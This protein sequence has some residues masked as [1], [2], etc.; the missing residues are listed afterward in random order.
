LSD[1]PKFA[2]VK[3]TG[4]TSDWTVYHESVC[5][6]TS[7][8]LVLNSTASVGNIQVWGAA[9][10]TSSVIGLTS[11]GAVATNQECIA[12]CWA[13]SSTQSFGS[14][15]GNGSTTGPVIDCGF[16][17]A[18]V[19]IKRTNGA[20]PWNMYDSTRSPSNPANALLLANTSDSETNNSNNNIDFLSTGFQLGTATPE[21][22]GSGDTY[23][24]AAFG[25]SFEGTT[26]ELTDDSG[27]TQFSP[28][29]DIVQNGSGTPVSSA[30]T[31]VGTVSGPIYS[32]TV[33]FTNLNDGTPEDM[34]DGSTSTA[35]VVAATSGSPNSSINWTTLSSMQDGNGNVT[36]AVRIYA[37][38]D[39]TY[40]YPDL[41]LIQADDT[42][43]YQN[44]QTIQT[45]GWLDIGTVTF[46]RIEYDH[47]Y[48]TGS[49]TTAKINAIELDG[50][51]L[52][53]STD[54]YNVL[55]LTDDTNL[56]NFRVGDVVQSQEASGV[57]TQ[58]PVNNSGD[59]ITTTAEWTAILGVDPSDTSGP[60]VTMP[61][62]GGVTA[63]QGRIYFAGMT[64]GD[65]ITWFG[66]ATDGPRDC[67]GNVE[68][69]SVNLPSNSLGSFQVTVTAPS[70]YF[71]VDWSGSNNICYGLIPS[72]V[73][74]TVTVYAID[75]VTP[76]ITTDG[77]TWNVGDPVTGPSFTATGTVAS[78]DVVANTMT[79]STS[80]GR[81][82]VTEP[83]YQEDL[84]LNTKAQS[85]D[86]VEV[87][88]AE[89]FCIFDAEGNISDLSSNDPGFKDMLSDGSISAA[90]NLTFPALFPSMETP[91]ERLPKGTTL[92]V[93]AKATN[94]IGSAVSEEACVTPIEGDGPTSSMYGLRFDSERITGLTNYIA[95]SGTYTFA[96]WV[97]PTNVVAQSTVFENGAT[98]STTLAL[99]YYN[100]QLVEFLASGSNVIDTSPTL[101]KW[102][103]YIAADDGTTRKWYKNGV[104]I[105][106]FS[107]LTL[108]QETFGIGYSV[109]SPTSTNVVFNGYLSE[110]Y[111]VDG[112]ALPPTAFGYDYENQGKWAPLA[113][114]VIKQ[115]IAAAG[116]FGENGFYLPFNPAATGQVWSAGSTGWSNPT[117]AFDGESDTFAN[118]NSSSGT[119]GIFSFSAISGNLKLYVTTDQ[120]DDGT[121]TYSFTLSDGSVLSTDKGY[122][123]GAGAVIDF[124]TVSN[125]TS[126]TA[127]SGGMI[128][129]VELDGSILVDH[130]NIGVDDSG[131]DNNFPTKT[132]R[133]VTPVRFGV[134]GLVQHQ[135]I[136]LTE[137]FQME[138][139]GILFGL[140]QLRLLL[141][142]H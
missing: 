62:G 112:Q 32:S 17:P 53:D 25:N 37:Q 109:A 16:E 29:D 111:T 31:N 28:G 20:G 79:L 100:N 5:D 83:D 105:A 63:P 93:N 72:I 135:L 7:E 82:L 134:V 75:L 115:N 6:T 91:D 90:F 55:T 30:I 3:T 116:G 64:V 27:L 123:G 126:I 54:P 78:V 107:S 122:S 120:E 81:W 56:A 86:L 4:S 40:G 89:L 70:G 76:S 22:N 130:N 24:Y 131:N 52:V 119:D 66:T 98:G 33:T 125:I 49:S 41:K 18:F 114:T 101:N 61:D 88:S 44:T 8:Y 23:I 35:L 139:M 124:G 141:L 57:T 84:K 137:T 118:S 80:D 127:E 14:Y 73:N 140:I 2:I 47:A 74:S 60:S 71:K 48:K 77:G 94:A 34:F 45:D 85:T 50:E 9:L 95:P 92:C 38:I 97:K 117:N 21:L 132:L 46:N 129:M 69:T 142:H 10:P 1:A 11:G 36:A 133:S 136:C 15:T 113:S 67:G 87:D 99:A 102:C 96:F 42:I 68:E 121:A 138:M 12:Y 104:E 110:F 59:P 43:V 108:V 13:E 39:G 58:V 26:L 51:I 106:S 128:W 103:S 65:T 19:L